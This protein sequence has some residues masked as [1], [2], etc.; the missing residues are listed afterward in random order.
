MVKF[1]KVCSIFN[2]I[3]N[4]FGVNFYSGALTNF[5]YILCFTF[6]NL[7]NICFCFFIPVK[8]KWFIKHNIYMA[9]NV[10]QMWLPFLIQN[11]LI[12]RTFKRRKKQEK[13]W[14]E[15]RPKFTQKADIC[16]KRFLIRVL[17]IFIIRMLKLSFVNG[18]H[19]FVFNMQTFFSELIYSSNDLMF[20]YYVELMIEYLDYI[21]RRI[22]M[23]RSYKE[24]RAIRREILDVFRVK[25]KIEKIYSINILI[26]LSYNF[27]LNIISFYWILM[28]LI[29]NH[30]NTI[31]EFA[32]FFHLL[33]PIFMQWTI[34]TVCEKFYKKVKIFSKISK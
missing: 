1:L 2:F 27:G 33:E 13:I 24:L 34:C 7:V 15:L 21:D 19:Y 29:F 12:F 18:P 22:D 14:M 25:R 11:L 20:V 16:E 5:Y 28:R 26:T 3:S 10:Y 32:S 17:I 31:Y 23:M 8:M 4:F 30:Y 9:T 6:I